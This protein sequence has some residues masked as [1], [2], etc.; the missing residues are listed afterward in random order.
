MKGMPDTLLPI[1]AQRIQIIPNRMVA[2]LVR[3]DMHRTR[4]VLIIRYSVCDLEVI[5]DII[6]IIVIDRLAIA[7]AVPAEWSGDALCDFGRF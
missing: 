4:D 1:P 6:E 5:T 2:V 3:Y 7:F